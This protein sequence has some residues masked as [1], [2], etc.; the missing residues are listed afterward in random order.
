ML[1]SLHTKLAAVFT[2]LSMGGC[3]TVPLENNFCMEETIVSPFGIGPYIKTSRYKRD[4]ARDSAAEQN[5]KLGHERGDDLMIGVGQAMQESADDRNKQAMDRAIEAAANPVKLE[6]CRVV[7][8]A[9]T[10]SKKST[11]TVILTGCVPA[12]PADSAAS[13]PK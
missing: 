1:S 12:K 11:R 4:C 5:K 8:A 13:G 2:T 7:P 9:Q 10:G 6:G 3:M